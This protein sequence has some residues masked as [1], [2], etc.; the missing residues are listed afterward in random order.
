[1]YE[2]FEK[3]AEEILST[4]TLK[5][6]VGQLN[7]VPQPVAGNLEETKERIRRGEIGSFILC[8]SPTAGN[9]E[10]QAVMVD[11]LN[12]LQKVA[13]E[14]SRTGIPLLYGRDVI[15]GHHTVYPIGLAAACSF[16]PELVEECYHC[17]AKEAASESVHWTFSPMI[18]V[19]HE[20]RWGRIIEGQGEDPYL[21]SRMAE[22]MVKGFQGEDLT[23]DDS[24]LACAKHYVGYGA[25]EGGRDYFRT[26]I[27]DYTLFNSI[28]PP[29]RAAVKAGV[30]TVMSSF[31]D[32]NGQ[33]VT[34]SKKYLTDILRDELGFEG[35]VVSDWTAV[36]QLMKQGVARNSADCA[37]MA[38]TAGLD[39]EMTD[40]HYIANLE[41]LV[42]S[43]EISEEVVDLAVKRV[44]KIKLAKGLFDKP[45]KKPYKVDRAEHVQ[46]SEKIA[47]ESMVLVKNE[48]NL[49]PLSKDMKVALYGPFTYERRALQG[50]WAL[51]GY[52]GASTPNFLEAM[53]EVMA[54][55][56]GHIH[57]SYEGVLHDDCT[58]IF[59]QNDVIVLALGESH[60]A[61]GEARC[62]ADIVLA[63]N[64][65][66]MARKAKQSG[67]KVVGVIFCGRPLALENIEPYLDAILI[68]WHGGTRCAHAAAKTIFGEYNPCGKTSVT[69]VRKTGQIPL[70]YNITKS[71][72][73]VDGYYG[74]GY[75]Q[76]YIDSL[77]SPMYPFG[78]GLSY[79]SF[80]YSA[81]EVDKATI[82][83][84]SLMAGENVRVSAKIKNTGE[85]TG[86]ETVQ[87]Y[88][89]DHVAS[90][91]RPIR[92]L[93]GFE[94][95]ELEAGEEKE[96]VF[97]VGAESLGFYNFENKYV[98]EKGHIDL[99]I[100]E[101]CLTNN[102]VTIEII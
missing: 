32:I 44:L 3:R 82:S 9:E 95:I 46:L 102:L 51:D 1:M 37:K 14:E 71:G 67:K 29:F 10:Q 41:N 52:L 48:G 24:M 79:T 75:A 39:M 101:N 78:Y 64:Q 97:N 98:V 4:L 38:L 58:Y 42:L 6:K 93:K 25:S 36:H 23:A 60:A 55:Q 57:F 96:V 91:M 66:E 22:A 89:R 59:S 43:G 62:S 88:I 13:V 56:K 27:S 69:F 17:I 49:L 7:Q 80:E 81:P 50:S 18:D 19:C 11:L 83:L 73:N 85:R 99:F 5:E 63:P 94:K 16:N 87:L 31:N 28:L 15:H 77:G 26:E 2:K 74:E 72:R 33:P 61:T 45:Y 8:N 100:G 84:D 65:V 34:S 86:K 12:E 40:N 35:F 90:C 20:P 47:A 70:Y 53:N 76:N 30:A 92:E 68:A 21:A 54:G